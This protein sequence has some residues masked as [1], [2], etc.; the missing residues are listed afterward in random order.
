MKNYF[1][2]DAA[3][4]NADLTRHTQEQKKLEAQI[5]EYEAKLLVDPDNKMLPGV[6]ATYRS[7]LNKLMDSKAN[8]T[9][10]IGRK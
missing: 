9:S 1:W 8:V 7:F 6:L 2:N 5:V 3:G 4:V 10:K